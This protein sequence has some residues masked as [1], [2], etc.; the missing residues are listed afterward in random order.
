MLPRTIAMCPT[1]DDRRAGC[2][3]GSLLSAVIFRSPRV[4]LDLDDILTCFE[5]SEMSC[6][7]FSRSKNFVIISDG[8]SW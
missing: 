2:V 3:K 7:V 5:S 6:I 8:L 4:H 1:K